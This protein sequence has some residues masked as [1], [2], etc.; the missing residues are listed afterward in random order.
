MQA[1]DRQFGAFV[2]ALDQQAFG[3]PGQH[4]FGHNRPAERALRLDGRGLGAGQ[5]GG[6]DQCPEALVAGQWQYHAFDAGNQTQA[7]TGETEAARH[8]GDPHVI[9]PSAYTRIGEAGKPP[10]SSAIC[11]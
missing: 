11:G 8:G 2:V 6:T 9:R 3:N 7:L 1:P 5:A 4:P 10:V